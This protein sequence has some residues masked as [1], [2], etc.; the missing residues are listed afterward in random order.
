MR[1]HV[2]GGSVVLLLGCSLA[3][4]AVWAQGG[5]RDVGVDLGPRNER[6]WE[7][8]PTASV[9]E[10]RP[11][12]KLRWYG[13]QN[14]LADGIGLGVFPL[15]PG[16]SVG[17]VMFGSALIHEGHGRPGAAAASL[18]LRVAIPAAILLAS[19]TS[20]CGGDFCLPDARPA[21]VALLCGMLVDDLALSWERV[22]TSG[23]SATGFRFAPTLSV[24]S[25][26]G[27]T[28]L[29]GSF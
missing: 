7:P 16:V 1:L 29:A 4:R 3:S 9:A 2:L 26:G 18:A 12:S 13:Y 27:F 11:T 22:P 23:A 25:K 21:L 10:P 24:S 14:F 28:G 5:A 17:V 20:D 15:Q 8:P 6:P 19:P